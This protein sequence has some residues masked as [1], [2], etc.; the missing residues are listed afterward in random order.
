[1]LIIGFD[2]YEKYFLFLDKMNLIEKI[3]NENSHVHIHED[4][5]FYVE[6]IIRSLINDGRNMLHVVADFDFTLTMYEKDGVL[7][8]STFGIIE[9]SDQIA[10]RIKL[11]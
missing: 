7:L 11:Y 3:L 8:P 4:K 6:E 1:V 10:V 5:R 2:F 9:S